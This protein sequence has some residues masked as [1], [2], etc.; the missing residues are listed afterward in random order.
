MTASE[1]ILSILSVFVV[2]LLPQIS[3][4]PKS[5]ADVV[6]AAYLKVYDG[7]SSDEVL[8]QDK[9]NSAFLEACHLE[10]PNAADRELNWTMLNLRKA[11]KLG[12]K[13]TRRSG[14][15]HESH[16]HAAEI[17]ARMIE[18][19]HR[20]NIDRAFCDPKLRIAFDGHARRLAPK[21]DSDL[22]RR[23]AMG[24]RKRRQLKPE[25]VVRVADW[26]RKIV[27]KSTSELRANPQLIPDLPGVYLF[28]DKSGY[29]YIGESSSLRKRL[30]QHLDKSDRSSL[31]EY[32]NATR[33]VL[34]EKSASGIFVEMHAFAVDS[35][36]RKSEMR[37]AY[38]SELI[39]SRKPRLNV[40]P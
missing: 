24:L 2:V 25:L 20:L 34:G 18:D 38:E 12:G 13:V 31:A 9:L 27:T 4:E 35:P 23:A 33:H 22:L 26:N 7:W 29:L 37:R 17:A 16:R 32:L 11:K 1:L 10:L 8:I 21:V 15:R 40:R 30:T 36:A 39:S 6:R 14:S 19:K 3:D 28:M 5:Q